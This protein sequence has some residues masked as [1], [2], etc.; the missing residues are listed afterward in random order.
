MQTHFTLHH[1][2]KIST[3]S[4]IYTHSRHRCTH[5]H[6]DNHFSLIHVVWARSRW[7]CKVNCRVLRSREATTRLWVR[8]QTRVYVC[9][10]VCFRWCD[11]SGLTWSSTLPPRAWRELPG[12]DTDGGLGSPGGNFM[13]WTKSTALWQK[14]TVKQAGVSLYLLNAFWM[15]ENWKTFISVSS[16][17]AYADNYSGIWIKRLMLC[18]GLLYMC[19]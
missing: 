2:H 14:W 16:I 11:I 18:L 3:S 12:K 15:L 17:K 9:V 8:E 4:Y 10:L 19:L 13:V 1:A 7:R 6:S 5:A